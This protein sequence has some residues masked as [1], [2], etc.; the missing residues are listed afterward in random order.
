MRTAAEKLAVLCLERSDT[1]PIEDVLR[2]EL[3]GK[4][5]TTGTKAIQTLYANFADTFDAT[6][7]QLGLTGD[8]AAK[9]SYLYNFYTGKM[10]ACPVCGTEL[11]VGQTTCPNGCVVKK[12]TNSGNYL[13][14]NTVFNDPEYIRNSL[15]SF[16]EKYGIEFNSNGKD[17][18]IESAK[19]YIRVC[20]VENSVF[21]ATHDQFA[22]AA[23]TD[24]CHSR[25]LECFQIYPTDDLGVWKSMI[26]NKVKRCERIFA[27]N[28]EVREVDN[29]TAL[30]F[31]N[32]NH[33]QGKSNSSVRLGLYYN[34]A[35]VSLMTFSKARFTNKYQWELV[36]FCSLKYHSVVGAAS[37]LFAAFNKKYR[38]VSV[39]SY[40]N[41]RFSHG[42][43]YRTL[44]FKLL[45]SSKPNYFYLKD[46]K[47]Y[48]R[49]HFQK[50]RLVN[51]PEYRSDLTET[52]I[53]ERAGYE[54]VYDCGNYVFARE[55]WFN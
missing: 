26:L 39:V 38:P 32:D 21:S 52:E 33:I 22:N 10:R 37:K 9:S 11:V 54:R 23:F 4:R 40:A 18:F 44:G 50:H 30:N 8:V 1:L 5:S 17:F 55:F 20:T 36:R 31:L 15:K 49:I 7:E 14:K 19:L 42:D 34:G 29:Q 47:I 51:M 24:K 46:K 53:M 3:Q 25:G 41:R 28:C 43:L 45:D 16:M 27:R 13:A 48:N 12:E 2:E 6:I 35:L